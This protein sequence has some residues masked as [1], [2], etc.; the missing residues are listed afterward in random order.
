MQRVDLGGR[1]GQV[2]EPEAQKASEQ[3]PGLSVNR[4]PLAASHATGCRRKFSPSLDLP[5]NRSGH[6]VSLSRLWN[7]LSLG[8]PS[9]IAPGRFPH[10]K[11]RPL[12]QTQRHAEATVPMPARPGLPGGRGRSSAGG[13]LCFVGV[14]EVSPG[15]GW[16]ANTWLPLSGCGGQGSMAEHPFKTQPDQAWCKGRPAPTRGAFGAGPANCFGQGRGVGVSDGLR[17]CDAAVAVTQLWR[18]RDAALT[19]S[20]ESCHGGHV[21]SDRSCVLVTLCV[22]VFGGVTVPGA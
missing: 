17:G 9:W 3:G 5:S 16:C 7:F 14:P 10:P 13:G 4:A 12:L 11:A 6:R 15:R 18:G 20:Q 21:R 8:S 19:G 22:R 1:G 2:W